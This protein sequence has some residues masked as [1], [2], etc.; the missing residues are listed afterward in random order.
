MSHMGLLMIVRLTILIY[1]I[2]YHVYL[3]VLFLSLVL[4]LYLSLR[5]FA[6]DFVWGWKE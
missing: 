3:I 6:L 4:V 5:Y 1:Y 2:Q